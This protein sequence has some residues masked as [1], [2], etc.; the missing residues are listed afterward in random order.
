MLVIHHHLGN[1]CKNFN[2]MFFKSFGWLF[3]MLGYK[4]KYIKLL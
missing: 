2:V 4:H 3:V 1:T